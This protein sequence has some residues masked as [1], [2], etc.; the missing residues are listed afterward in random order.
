MCGIASIQREAVD[1]RVKFA[2][3]SN[4][5]SNVDSSVESSVR[6]SCRIHI[7]AFW[8]KIRPVCIPAEW[9][10]CGALCNARSILL[11]SRTAL[12]HADWIP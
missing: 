10:Q 9:L 11:S 8:L 12:E 5:D 4:V 3:E 6:I 1:C 2:V 7:G